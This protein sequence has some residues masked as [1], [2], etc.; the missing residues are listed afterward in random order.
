MR[1]RFIVFEGPE[2]SG[3]STQANRLAARL[4]ASGVP[5][6]LTREPG[7][8][9]IGERVRAILLSEQSAEM[10]PET[11]ALL[12]AA[13]RAQHVAEVLR[14]GVENGEIVIC[15]RFADS[16]IAYQAG[17]RGLPAAEVV[18][19]QRLATGGLT[20]D[21]RI[22]LDLPAEAGLARRFSA[23]EGVNRLDRAETAFHQRV[24]DCYLGLAAA[25]QDDWVVIDA[26]RS[27]EE[28]AG[29]VDQE[30]DRLLEGWSGRP[31]TNA[32]ETGS[33]DVE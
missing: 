20:P 27:P 14:P 18:G 23:D 17:G 21:L 1:G 5:V 11:E 25:A 6:R 32:A 3:K 12:Y 9:A 19:I 28:V 8:T 7:G 16:S 13:A 33:G 30:V 10:R 15:D 22:L 24:R 26:G 31:A 2:G 29:D 4:A